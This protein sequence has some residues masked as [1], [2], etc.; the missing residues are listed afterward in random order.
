MLHPTAAPAAALP[1]DPDLLPDVDVVGEH[2]FGRRGVLA[3]GRRKLAIGAAAVCLLSIGIHDLPAAATTVQAEVVVAG[4]QSFSTGVAPV[5]VIERSGYEVSSYTVVQ[6]PINPGT[7]LSSHFGNRVAPCAEC[8]SF[9]LGIDWNPGAGTRIE[10]IADGTVV[11]VDSISGDLGVHVV[12]EHDIDGE[13]VQSVYGHM[14][15]GSSPLSIGQKVSRGDVV[16]RVGNSGLSTG[17]HLHF[18]MI[19]ASGTFIDPLAWM[20]AHVNIGW[21]D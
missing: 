10:S 21:G 15:P 16:G 7:R 19:T 9:H 5:A 4:L 8:S 11:G 3:V 2:V 14:V 12:I 1:H 6:W 18:A 17:T 20:R 13:R